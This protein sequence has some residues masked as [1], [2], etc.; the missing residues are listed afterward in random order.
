MEATVCW[1]WATAMPYPGTMTMDLAFVSNSDVSAA[2]MGTASPCSSVELPEDLVD[3]L[4]PNPPRMT[5][6]NFRFMA[7][8]MMIERMAPLEPTRAPTTMR[9]SLESMNPVAAAA[10]P[11]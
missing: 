2:V 10:Q 7:R 8:H 3:F 6:M 4:V 9:R 11:E 5:L 1:A